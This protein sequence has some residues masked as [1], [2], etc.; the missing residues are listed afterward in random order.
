MAGQNPEFQ[1]LQDLNQFDFDNISA[2]SMDHLLQNT[3]DQEPYGQVKF[4]LIDSKQTIGRPNGHNLSTSEMMS[5]V[6]QTTSSGSSQQGNSLLQLCNPNSLSFY[7]AVLDNTEAEPNGSGHKVG[8]RGSSSSQVESTRVAPELEKDVICQLAE[9]SVGLY[10]HI[11][12]I[13]PISIHDS[14]PRF[15]DTLAAGEN[16]PNP[17]IDPRTYNFKPEDTFSLSQK[18]V[19][20]Y[21]NIM[22]IFFP[23]NMIRPPYMGDGDFDA[24]ILRWRSTNDDLCNE[25]DQRSEIPHFSTPAPIDQSSLLLLLSCHLRLLD[26]FDKLFEHMHICTDSGLG[27]YNVG[28]PFQPPQVRVGSFVAPPS[29][30]I[31][32]QMLLFI[33][34]AS[35]LSEYASVLHSK[36]R[37]TKHGEGANTEDVE[38]TGKMRDLTPPQDSVTWTIAESVKRRAKRATE[39]ISRIRGTLLQRGFFA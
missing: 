15:K 10:E 25:R 13:P 8:S 34:L 21:P 31:P 4:P 17:Q 20:V 36:I 11:K 38:E 30:A 29:S 35:Q 16:A 14:L 33:Q 5:S 23:D 39:E 28:T 12:S 32:M 27:A 22:S 37:L 7:H 1:D 6:S 24:W 18:L 9:L 3:S 2:M 26:I 19:D